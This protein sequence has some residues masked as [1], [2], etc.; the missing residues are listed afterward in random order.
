MSPT[1]THVPWPELA[2]LGALFVAV[3]AWSASG[4]PVDPRGMSLAAV[5]VLIALSPRRLVKAGHGAQAEA[6]AVAAALGALS[7]ATIVAGFGPPSAALRIAHALASGELLGLSTVLAFAQPMRTASLRRAALPGLFVAVLGTAGLWPGATHWFPGA[8]ALAPTA[9]AVAALLHLAALQRPTPPV[10]R[11]RWIYPTLGV[12]A[13]AL[14]TIARALSG[15][16]DGALFAWGLGVAAHVVGLVVGH[17]DTS[18][19]QAG[20]FARRTFAACIGFMTGAVALAFGPDA[21]LTAMGVGLGVAAFVLPVIDRWYRP[22][23]G[24]LLDACDRIERNLARAEGLDE[25]AAAVL[26]PLREAA[27]NLRAPA[28]F[29]VLEGARVLRVDVAGTPSVGAFSIE[30]EKALVTWLRTRPSVVFTDTLRPH[31]VRRPELR[32]VA[33]ALDA[34][35]AFAA[36]PLC[37]ADQ[38]LG[39]VLVPRGERSTPASFE[40]E[41]RL[42]SVRRLVEGA[43]LRILAA[44]RSAARAAEA[45]R[46]EAVE[47]RRAEGA[48]R[49]LT[50]VGALVVESSSVAALG[51]HATRWVAY[52]P[53]SR[54]LQSALDALATTDGPVA[55]VAAAN[56]SARAAAARLHAQGPRAGRGLMVF[57]A[58]SVDARSVLPALLGD[59]RGAAPSPGWLERAAGAT[60]L[61]E[62]AVALGHEG[63]T[64][65]AGALDRGVGRRLGD[66]TAYA[67]DVRVIVTLPREPSE[68]DLPVSLLRRVID[69]SARVP[70]LRERPE[71]VESLVYAAIDR[72]CRCADRS[73]LGIAPDALAALRSYAWPGELPELDAALAHAVTAARGSRIQGDD[74]PPVVRASV[75]AVVRGSDDERD[76]GAS[77]DD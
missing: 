26:D 18:A 39:V 40:E 10:E 57:D 53:A 65:L 77:Y 63:L 11:A 13:L 69:R 24:R 58:S 28:A 45:Q 42:E 41:S 7:V 70:A 25:L 67:V 43:L 76:R 33:D 32:P 37:D 54:A 15:S 22:V 74:L 73:P 46:R 55:L 72:A 49:E 27:R 12:T 5:A 21:P 31:L 56:V 38:L 16:G 52:A 75:F 47:R 29:W 17:A 61:V 6:I 30:A 66:E 48:E 8:R 9:A 20:P 60:L 23:E 64:A 14:A 19:A 2:A 62:N 59:A 68:C 4:R 36:V 51:A 35:E 1:R 3:A 50:R 44:E 34:H 71:D